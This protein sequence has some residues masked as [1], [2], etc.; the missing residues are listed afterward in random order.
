MIPASVLR[1]LVVQQKRQIEKTSASVERSIL[2]MVLDAFSDN[3]VLILTGIRRCG[4]ST[5]LKQIMRTK[6]RYCYVN[7]EDERLLGF[8]AEDFEDLNGLLVEVYGPSDTYF[9]D[10]IQNID[11]FE[12]FVRRLQDDGK[13]IVIT[14]SN[15]SM[16][17]REFGTRLTGRYKL[18]EVFPFSFEEFLRA[19]K[20][21]MKQDSYYLPEEKAKLVTAFSMYAE[22]GGMPEYLKN[23]DSEYIKTLY[24][25]IIYR[26]II[27]RYSIRRQR[28]VRELVGI[29]AST[30]SLPFTYNSLKKSLGL[31]NAITVK[32]YI[33]YLSGAYLFFELLRFDF[34]VK[35]Q[36]NSARKIY[37]IDTAFSI[38][39]GFSFSPN[40]GR[41]LENMV[42]IELR[43]RGMEVYYYG[44]TREC[45]FITKC[46][47]KITGA[48]QVC[49]ELTG[50]NRE[51]E[52]TGLLEAMAALKLKEGTILTNGQE[53]LITT[54]DFTIRI[55]PVWKWLL[56]EPG[57]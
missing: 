9:F 19:K 44:G 4:K 54:G 5:L 45:D 52:T 17:S 25:N 6:T 26:D 10:E 47:R 38:L 39:Y 56:H 22:N 27:A 12:T 7:F 40:S 1:Q 3:R 20:I 16:L 41:L 48:F 28:L 24:D 29:L 37:I 8:R 21:S 13:K 30:V 32:E 51:R 46:G 33:S 34:S 57:M 15:A 43:R 49:Y 36:L 50:E 18:F 11:R 53:D 23:H 14:G 42:F 2:P 55:E 31:K 35:K